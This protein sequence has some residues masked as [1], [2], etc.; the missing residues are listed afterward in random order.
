M[1]EKLKED[2][3]SKKEEIEKLKLIDPKDMYLSDLTDL[4]KKFK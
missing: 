2:F 1:F 4:K 3:S